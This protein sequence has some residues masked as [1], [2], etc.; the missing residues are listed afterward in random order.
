MKMLERTRAQLAA[1]KIRL[2]VVQS[3]WAYR[4]QNCIDAWLAL[5][6]QYPHVPVSAGTRKSICSQRTSRLLIG[7]VINQ[8]RINVL[9]RYN[10]RRG[11]RPAVF[12]HLSHHLP[13]ISTVTRSWQLTSALTQV[14]AEIGPENT[15]LTEAESG[16]AGIFDT[17]VSL[18]DKVAGLVH[19]KGFETATRSTEQL[20]ASLGGLQEGSARE[21][22]E[23]IR[24]NRH[25]LWGGIKNSILQ[26]MAG[27]AGAGIKM[28]RQT[29]ITEYFAVQPRA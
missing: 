9:K 25:E 4:R 2:E 14:E 26:L 3:D 29:M 5:E 23:E 24:A 6:E 17:F 27:M 1:I 16:V 15:V 13:Q 22:I 19:S 18:H 11:D 8:E 21:E 28:A 12:H 20:E 7:E 10:I